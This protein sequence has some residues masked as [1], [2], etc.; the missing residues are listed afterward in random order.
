ME[1]Q[2]EKGE[3]TKIQATGSEQSVY[4]VPVLGVSVLGAEDDSV[5][6]VAVY[7]PGPW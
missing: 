7:G 2:D 1:S 3:D 5:N 4:A 6:N